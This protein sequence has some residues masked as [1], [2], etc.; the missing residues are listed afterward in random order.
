MSNALLF[1]M[2]SGIPGDISRRQY[3]IVDSAVPNAAKPFA[4]YGLPAKMVSGKM[5]PIE[6]GDLASL[7]VGF[8]VRPYPTQTANADGTGLSIAA[9]Y[10]RMLRGYMTVHNYAGSPAING[11]VYMRVGGVDSTHPVGGIE[12]ADVH[13]NVG[14][15]VGGNTGNGTIGTISVDG[16]AQIGVYTFKMTAATTFT[17]AAPDGTQFKAG[18]TG[19]AYTAGGVTATITVGGTPMVAGDSFTVTVVRNTVAIPNCLFQ[20]TADASGNVEIAY[21]V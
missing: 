5:E 2:L 3:T 11:Q 20:C 9:V 15:A 10:D 12:A 14:A 1:R 21:K 17:M 18:A 13:T 16:T 8:L 4:A 6:A 19:A 7:V